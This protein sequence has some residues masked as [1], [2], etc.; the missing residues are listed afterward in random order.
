MSTFVLIPG[1]GGQAWYWHRVVPEL[2]ARGHDAIAV[3]LP[4][5]DDS[6][7]L[8]EY[9]DVV[10]DAIGDRSGLV[11]VAQSMGGFTA[12]MVCER[13]PADL[14]VLVNAM[15]PRP[16]ESP[17]EWWANTGHDQ[18]I[19]NFD[20]LEFFFHDVPPEVT[21]EAMAAGE[22][23]QSGTPFAKPWPLAKWPD[24]RTKF[25][26]GSDDRFFPPDFQRPL[27]RERLGL[28]L[29]EMPGGHLVALSRPKDLAERLVNYLG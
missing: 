29:D 14:L 23:P 5:G 27:V 15:T 22:V 24:V 17:G 10:V 21:A 7:G 2:E 26:Q 8:A 1:A 11:L 18:L 3:D 19:E 4:A 6:A 12:P 25:L 16:G 28:E 13:V 20:L 9:A